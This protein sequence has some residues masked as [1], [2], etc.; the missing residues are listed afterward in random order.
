MDVRIYNFKIFMHLSR[1]VFTSYIIESI[2]TYCS[3]AETFLNNTD[4][5]EYQSQNEDQSLAP[6]SFDSAASS[7]FEYRT[8][9]NFNRSK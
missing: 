7:H 3:V 5:I 4:L 9:S 6:I 8:C 1:L 2:Y